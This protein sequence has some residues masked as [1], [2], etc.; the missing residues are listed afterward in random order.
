MAIDLRD[1]V[2]EY[3]GSKAYSELVLSSPFVSCIAT[4]T[5]TRQQVAQWE[6]YKM[7]MA[8]FVN[9]LF[10]NERLGVLRRDHD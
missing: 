4:T 6:L 7:A 3:L 1:E 9:W 10:D 2:N 8:G 5:P